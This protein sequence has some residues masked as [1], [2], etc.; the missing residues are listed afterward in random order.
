[1]WLKALVCILVIAFCIA[2]GYFASSSARS[3]KAFYAHF[4]SFHERY[5]TELSYLRR[6]IREFLK[7]KRYTGDF[8]RL[9]LEYEKTRTVGK[10][11]SFFKTDE[12]HEIEEYFSTLGKGDSGSQKSYFA[13]KTAYISQKKAESEKDSRKKSELY[14]KLG[15]LAG[16]AIV[17]LIV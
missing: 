5:L 14:L 11:P 15:L 16:L 13:G 17:I 10:K 6:P 12:F 8:E 4:L 7:E 2:L 1:M 9:V 3:K